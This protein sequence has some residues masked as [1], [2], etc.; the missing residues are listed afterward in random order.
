MGYLNYGNREL[1]RKARSLRNSMTRPEI[2]FWSKIRSKQI[3]GLKFRRQQPICDYIVDFY[4]DSIKLII[5]IDGEIHNNS[6]NIQY[7]KIRETDLINHGFQ[8]LRFDN[9]EVEFNLDSVLLRL[10]SFLEKN[11]PELFSERSKVNEK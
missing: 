11:Y 10:N 3:F 5:E 2:I 7:D 8:I 1:V 6:D 4:C 9:D